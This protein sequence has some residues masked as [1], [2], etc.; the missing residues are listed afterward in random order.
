CEIDREARRRWHGGLNVRRPSAFDLATLCRGTTGELGI[1]S[2]TVDAVC[3]RFVIAR[4][5][6]FPKT[7]RFRS[8][9]RSLYWIPVSNFSR[10]ARLEGD[11]LIF[12]KRSYRLWMSR[13]LPE[14]GKPKSWNMACDARGRWY[15]NIQVEVPEAE[16]RDGPA[17]G[18]DLGLKSLATLSD[19]RKIEAPQFYR[20]AQA[21]LARW[22]RFGKKKRVRALH[23]KVTN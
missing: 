10:P 7:P 21:D 19:G 8:A 17:I 15:V 6:I 14:N 9:K 12:R 1:H 5:T 16:K 13:P 18:I 11:A 2:D 23:A 22:Q 4:D 20:K 3:K